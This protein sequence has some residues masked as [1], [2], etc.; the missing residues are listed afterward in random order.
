M[1]LLKRT[2]D[3]GANPM[4]APGWPELA[5]P[6]ISTAKVRIVLIHFQSSSPYVDFVIVERV[7]R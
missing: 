4:G 1:N 3:M 5:L 7:R 2:W 6:G